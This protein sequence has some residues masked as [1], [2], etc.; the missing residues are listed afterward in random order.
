MASIMRSSQRGIDGFVIFLFEPR[1]QFGGRHDL[2]DAAN[3]LTAAPDLLP[4]LWLGALARGIG[5]ETHFRYVGLRQVLRIHAGRN[6]RGLQVIAVNAGEQVGIDDVF[7][8]R[9]RDHLLIALHRV[10]LGGG[11]EG[12]ANIGEVGAEQP[13][14]PYSAAVAD[15]ARKRDW[16]IEPL[17]SLRHECERRYL[18]GMTASAGG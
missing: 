9:G 8:A 18:A 5:A 6:D 2:A 1:D 13:R 10:R 4:G 15:C 16:P 17:P 7:R 14:G 11:C 12:G 3:A